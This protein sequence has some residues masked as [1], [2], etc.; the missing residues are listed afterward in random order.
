MQIFSWTSNPRPEYLGN[1]SAGILVL[2]GTLLTLNLAA[3]LLRNR[4]ERRSS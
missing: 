1:A 4:Y 2:M 3:I